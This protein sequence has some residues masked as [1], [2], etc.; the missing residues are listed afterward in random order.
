MCER[1]THAFQ[2][3]DEDFSSLSTLQKVNEEKIV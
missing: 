3:P 1:K 2:A